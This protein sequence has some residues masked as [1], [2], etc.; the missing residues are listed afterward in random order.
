MIVIL[1]DPIILAYLAEHLFPHVD[2]I[3]LVELP[4]YHQLFEENLHL[5]HCVLNGVRLH[6]FENI[7]YYLSV[8]PRLL[9]ECREGLNDRRRLKGFEHVLHYVV[10]VLVEP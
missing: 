8:E 9:A 1:V 3:Y 5:Y 6:L 10:H 2:C 4:L 7:T